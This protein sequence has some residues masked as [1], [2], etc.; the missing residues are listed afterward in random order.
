MAPD[1]TPVAPVPLAPSPLRLQGRG[2]ATDYARALLESLGAQPAC[3][4]G[5]EDAAAGRA[6]AL[7]GLMSLTGAPTGTGQMCPVPLASCADG[8]LRA[9]AC[10]APEDAREALPAGSLLL[11]ERAAIAGLQRRGAIS[12]GGACHLMPARDGWIAVNLARDADWKD[13]PAW[14]ELEGVRSWDAVVHS[15]ARRDAAEL[16]ERARLLGLAACV[17]AP[18]A[19][20]PQAW[21]TAVRFGAAVAPARR[22]APRVLDLSSLWAGPLCTHLLGLAGA[23]VIKVEDPGRP[24]GAR[25]GPAAFHDLMNHGKRSV[26]LPFDHRGAGRLQELIDAADIVVEASRPRALRQLGVVA[27]ECIARRPGLT[28]LS[29]TGYGREEPQGGWAA[30]GDDAG[31][32]AGLSAL[33]QEVCGQPLICGDAIA[34]PLTGMHAALAALAGYRLG[35]GLLVSLA[36][37]DVVAHCIA[38]DRPASHDA[39]RERWRAWAADATAH[40]L[41]A[42]PPV[43]RRPAGAAPALGADDATALAEWAA[44]C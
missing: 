38:F 10:L 18:P 7:C 11:G 8:A 37:R 42:T 21:Y 19:P 39:L 34:D 12:P 4:D 9:L 24:D 2:A 6:W 17:S 41:D 22:R 3:V 44:A 36:L 27:E 29:I 25:T 33:M 28:W 14:L 16:V 13:V 5:P 20:A 15:V 35:G 40:G 23:R 43:A 26:A 30:Y 31:V 32:A 1:S